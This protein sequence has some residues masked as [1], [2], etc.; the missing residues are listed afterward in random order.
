MKKRLSWLMALC[1]MVT[2]IVPTSALAANAKADLN[3]AATKKAAAEKAKLLT[4][5]FGTTSVQYALIDHGKIVVSGQV[6]KN[7]ALGK[8]PLTK[9]TIY[10]IGSTSKVFTAAAVM[11]L[12]DDG[13]VSLD[14]PVVQYIPDFTMKDE[15]YKNITIRM[16]LNHSSGLR[17]TTMGS[18]FLLGDNDS[19]AHDTLLNQL[20]KQTLKADPGAYSV[21][22]NDGF[23]LA[24]IVVERVSGMSFTQ[25]LH[26]YFTEPLAMNH[27]KTPLDQVDSKKFAGIYHPAFEGQLPTENT[28]L[29]GSGGIY[30]TA[31]DL[32]RFSQIFTGQNDKILSSDSVKAMRAEEFKKGMWPE[33]DADTTLNYGL[34]WDS[35]ELYPFNSYGIQA[36]NKGGDTFMYHASLVVLPEQNMAAAVLSSSGSSM[37]NTMLAND[38][39]LQALKEKGTIKEFKAAKSFG[40]PVKASM[41]ADV[42]KHSGYYAANDLIMKAAITKTGELSIRYNQMPGMPEEK[43]VYTAD[44]SFVNAEGKAKVRFVTRDN[45][46]TYLWASSYMNRPGFPQM[47]VSHYSGEK[48]TG[49]EISKEVDAAWAKRTGKKYFPVTEKYNSAFYLLVDSIKMKKTDGL[50]GYVDGNEILGPD[51]ASNPV[52]IPGMNG[53][54]TMEYNFITN[55]G[56][57]YLDRAGT[58]FVSEDTLKPFYLG[59]QSTVT[60]QEN[61][62]ARWFK[63]PE[64][65]AGKK[66][67][68]TSMPKHASFTVYNELGQPV[69]YMISSAAKKGIELQS[70][71][72]IVFA[73]EAGAKF[74]IK[75]N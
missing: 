3:Y 51:S 60:I 38:M 63:L 4:E 10:G 17:G 27:T 50:T 9:D 15:R 45:G 7:D 75:M 35:V 22:C 68:V 64:A 59:S 48:I 58:L 8:V 14:S 31:E 29:I 5:S 67:T 39:I 47:A 2:M 37:T 20:Q 24:E 19:Q 34:G 46:R 52:Q 23:T 25:F 73:G 72:T 53:R 66:L 18:A 21:Y 28:N 41:P 32:V 11:K 12:V 61:G 44:G 56:I 69:Q 30:S 36:E 62:Y 70:S 26:K 55:D 65:A 49:N 6:G 74:E 40:K 71:G 33:G 54:D 13:K 16:L 43:Y 42:A 1:L 57:E